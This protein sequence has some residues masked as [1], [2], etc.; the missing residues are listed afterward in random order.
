VR[1]R[2]ARHAAC[3]N[4]HTRAPVAVLWRLLVLF[5]INFVCEAGARG[6]LTCPCRQLTGFLCV[7][8]EIPGQFC[9]C[10]ALQIA[11]QP[12]VSPGAAAGIAIAATVTVC[13]AVAGVVWFFHP[14]GRKRRQAAAAA[15]K[16]DDANSSTSG[17]RVSGAVGVPGWQTA[18]GST[19]KSGGS[20]FSKVVNPAWGSKGFI[21]QADTCS[22]IMF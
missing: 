6:D 18:C 14:A 5:S 2:G 17:R 16:Q 7:V 19:L 3:C 12:A 10:C 1:R 15:D 13:A 9:H 22:V 8:L 11:P 4:L 20:C 21:L